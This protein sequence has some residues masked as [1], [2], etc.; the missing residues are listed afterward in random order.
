M[1]PIARA[2][3]RRLFAALFLLSG[4]FGNVGYL[5]TASDPLVPALGASGAIY[6]IVGSLAILAPFMMV[7]IYGMVPLPMVAAA[8][9]WALMDLMRLFVPSGIAHGAH[10]GGMLVGAV[11]GLYLRLRRR[12][13]DSNRCFI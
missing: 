13:L 6:G 7:F 5:I 4:I 12:Q 11:F 9:L 2:R 3:G 10:L 1:Y 8:L